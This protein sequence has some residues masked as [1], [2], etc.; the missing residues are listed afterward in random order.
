MRSWKI[1]LAATLLIAVTGGCS[2]MGSESEEP[3]EKG[4]VLIAGA[5]GG[6]GQA[7]V[8]QA[9]D[10]GYSVRVL[11]RDREKAATLFGERVTYVVGDVREPRTLRAAVRG[12]RY[13]ISTVGSNGARDPENSPELVDYGGV[14][15]LAEAAK[16]ARVEQFV[17]TSSMGVTNPDNQLNQILDNILQW[18][19]KGENAVRATG[20]PYTIVRPGGLTNEPGG[21]HGLKVIQGDPKD[22]VGRISR[23]DVGAV[24]VHALGRKDAYGKTFEVIG[25]PSKASVEWDKLF[26]GLKPDVG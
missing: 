19:L 7:A 1:G 16:M 12:A 26:A 20:M 21:Q 11:V 5:T 4:L 13:V 2:M 25:D 22:V 18:K 6:T 14:K 8:E 15:A 17:L 10:K 9:L 3:E 23:A 24:L